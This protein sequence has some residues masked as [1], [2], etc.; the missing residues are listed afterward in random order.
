MLDSRKIELIKIL[1]HDNTFHSVASLSKTLACSQ[2]TI[3]NDLPIINAWFSERGLPRL[4]RSVAGVGMNPQL[5]KDRLVSELKRERQ[6]TMDEFPDSRTDAMMRLVLRKGRIS[7]HTLAKTLNISFS[8]VI[9]NIKPMSKRL[10]K[11]GLKLERNQSFLTIFGDEN[12]KRRAYLDCIRQSSKKQA[13]THYDD[14]DERIESLKSMMDEETVDEVRRHIDHIQETRHFEFSVES[15]INILIHIV[16]AI[17]RIREDKVIEISENELRRIQEKIEYQDAVEFT[18]SLSRKFKVV[19]TESETAYLTY[20]LLGASVAYREKDELVQYHPEMDDELEKMIG[21]VE[22][23]LTTIFPDH[24]KIKS[25]LILHI[26][27]ALERIRVDR[28]VE[29]PLLTKFQLSHG[30][31]FEAVRIAI[32]EIEV[33][34]GLTFN[35]DEL[36]YIAMHFAANIPSETS[37][38]NENLRILLV[39]SSGVGTSQLL[40][41]R[42][43]YFFDGYEIVD[44]VSKSRVTECLQ[45]QRFD[46]IVTTVPL[47]ST[48]M[49]VIE[50]TPLLSDVD[51]KRLGEVLHRRKTD[52]YDEKNEILSEFAMIVNQVTDQVTAARIMNEVSM[53]FAKQSGKV[54]SKSV[55]GSNSSIVFP[56]GVVKIQKCMNLEGLIDECAQPL[57]ASDRIRPEYIRQLKAHYDEHPGWIMI[58]PGIAMPHAYNDGNVL[59]ASIVVALLEQRFEIDHRFGP[60]DTVVLLAPYDKTSH[61]NTLTHL[62]ELLSVEKTRDRLRKLA[63]SEVYDVIMKEGWL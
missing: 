23:H 31:I 39:C 18:Q 28:P 7:V 3:R 41:S 53:R 63:T 6:K 50:V 56:Q 40:A 34:H 27:P 29:N 30:H 8:T 43:S 47:K 45:K 49:N 14:L 19:F 26:I 62:I 9:A 46:H 52:E 20:H 61:V 11:Y 36:C 16:L 55:R 21:N 37:A 12:H 60:I 51:I 22:E 24:Q 32:S 2:R 38:T 33:N 57:L 44:I 4:E 15:Y 10:E 48:G 1:M 25:G 54:K 5:D 59:Q 42:L 13:L 17:Q 58:A 35:D